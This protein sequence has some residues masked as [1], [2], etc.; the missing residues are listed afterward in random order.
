MADF[1]IVGGGVYGCGAA[2]ELARRGAKVLLL[3]AKTI[4]SGASGGPGKRGVRANG[5]DRRELPLMRLAYSLWPPL[6]KAIH[7]DTGYAQTGHLMLIEREADYRTA[8]ARLWLQNQQGIPTR[9][10][11]GAE[12]CEREP[13]LSDQV[14]AALFCPHDGVADHTATTRGLADAARRLGAEIREATPVSGLERQG[15]RVTAVFTA[16]GERVPV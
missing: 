7:A 15:E 3:E 1:V 16:Q 6:H 8:H 10:V 12:L 14:K 2:W 5:R 4:A 13:H 9:L 11:E